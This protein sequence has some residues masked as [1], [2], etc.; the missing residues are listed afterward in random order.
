[1]SIASPSEPG[2]LRQFAAAALAL[3]GAGE[4][5]WLTWAALRRTTLPCVAGAAHDCASLVAA[6]EAWGLP[7]AV[8]GHLAYASVFLLALAGI[9]MESPWRARARGVWPVL[10]LAMAGTSALLMRQM[11]ASEHVCPWCVASAALS[12]GL[13]ALAVVEWRASRIPLRAA[14]G[15][16]ALVIALQAGQARSM[17]PAPA[18]ARVVA[19]ARHLR[20]SGARCYG[21]WWCVACREQKEL[22]GSA[23]DSLPYVDAEQ[24]SGPRIARFPT[25]VIAGRTLVG[26]LPLDTLA[27]RSGFRE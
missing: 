1:M 26:V 3:L 7:W 22:F 11:L 16:A 14:I 20:V 2:R 18:S 15:S 17:A 8:W 13:G 12:A 9:L 19:L 23:A 24:A 10:A 25:W 21:V 6:G 5:A 4:T 27:A